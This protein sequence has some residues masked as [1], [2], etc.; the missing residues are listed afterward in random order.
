M[1]IISRFFMKI[2]IYSTILFS[3]LSCSTIAKNK[4]RSPASIGD[5]KQN[6]SS[7]HGITEIDSTLI[8]VWTSGLII[9]TEKTQ[10]NSESFKRIQE[11][12][13]YAQS[14][15]EFFNRILVLDLH[16]R[17]P[18][19]EFYRNLAEQLINLKRELRPRGM[20]QENFL[21]QALIL[22]D[23]LADEVLYIGHLLFPETKNI[24]F[25]Y[26]NNTMGCHGRYSLLSNIPTCHGDIII[27]RSGSF[28][29]QFI[30]RLPNYPGNYSQA[31]LAY[32]AQEDDNIKIL[33]SDMFKGV[34]LH[35]SSR[36][37]L[38][39]DQSKNA[40][41]RSRST[42]TNSQAIAGL[43]LL[44]KKIEEKPTITYDYI[45]DG[46]DESA[47]SGAELI[48]YSYLLGGSSQTNPYPA[49]LWNSIGQR[50]NTF[51]LNQFFPINH[52]F[53]TPADIELNPRYQA[54]AMNY[55]LEQLPIE[56]IKLMMTD[57]LVEMA[58]DKTSSLQKLARKLMPL[59]N[60]KTS[61]DQHEFL[62]KVDRALETE[63]TKEMVELGIEEQFGQVFFFLLLDYYIAPKALTHTKRFSNDQEAKNQFTSLNKLK[64]FSHLAIDGVIEELI[65]SLDSVL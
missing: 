10:L 44:L 18:K 7:L 57:S 30:S 28:A 26:S 11:G 51:F 45:Q 20:E 29:D 64:S 13:Y 60:R 2:L 19:F 42:I 3:L 59:N 16:H 22:L 32:V 8:D 52:I 65:Q 62:V 37:K 55:N 15:D 6:G 58:S 38:F 21:R 24:R 41:F 46:A 39:M 31:S 53:P 9:G 54:I 63:L 34:S 5:E 27:S 17:Y 4:D 35:S 56:R 25:S 49:E 23:L 40:I 14:I 33:E 61:Q 36:A 48:Q 12:Y 43:D 1:D 47:L 50:G